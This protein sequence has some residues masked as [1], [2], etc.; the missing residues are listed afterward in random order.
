MKFDDDS[1]VEEAEFAQPLCT[2]VQIALVNLLQHWG[3]TPDAVVRHSSG[4]IAAAYASGA[5]SAEV[6]ILVAYFRGQAMKTF[7]S[8]HHGGMAAV[9][10]GSEKARPFLKPGVVIACDNSPESVTLSGDS[11]T[12]GEVLDGIH[13]HDN[14]ILCRQLAVNVAYHS[15][16]MV[17]AGEVYEKMVHPHCAHKLSMAP[18]YSNV[19]GTIISDPSILN[20]RYWRKNLQS[21]VLFNTAIQRIIGDDEQS[22]LFLEIG[23]HS[24]LSSPI[25][26][27][28]AKADTKDHRYLPTIIRGKEPW[29]SLLVTAGNL[30]THSAPIILPSLI[31]QGKVLTELPP[32]T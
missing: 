27:S 10:L 16:H 13:A 30:Y 6:A 2:A 3:I 25:R 26:Q 8:E 5:L 20:A 29:R 24:T 28:L 22:K 32:Y 7:S 12:L 14:E 11:D 23:P 21:P 15:H 9:G 31:A 18:M 19:S 4:E 1:R 17:E